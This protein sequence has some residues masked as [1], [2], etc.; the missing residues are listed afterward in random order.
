MEMRTRIFRFVAMSAWD[1]LAPNIISHPVSL[2]K[3]FYECFL[4]VDPLEK[5]GLLKEARDLSPD[6]IDAIVQALAA[7]LQPYLPGDRFNA[8]QLILMR[9]LVACLKAASEPAAAADPGEMLRKSLNRSILGDG[10]QQLA[11]VH[12]KPDQLAVGRS[13]VRAGLMGHI[14]SRG[15]QPLPPDPPPIP[16]YELQSVLGAGGFS[17]VYLAKEIASGQLRAVKVGPIEDKAR[18]DREIFILKSI[19]SPYISQYYQ[20]GELPG[21]FWIALEYLGTFTLSHL[22]RT[23]LEPDTALLLA[24]QILR[25]LVSLH[26]AG[27]IH[28][29]LTPNNIMID[30]EFRLKIIDFGLAKTLPFAL[31]QNAGTMTVGLTGTPMYMSPEQIHGKT[32]LAPSTDMWSFGVILYEML[33]GSPPFVSTNFMALGHEIQTAEIDFNHAQIPVEVRASLERCLKR[34]VADRWANAN[35][36]F[37]GFPQ[38]VMAARERIR[39]NRYRDSWQAVINKRLLQRFASE[40]SGQLP[41]GGPALFLALAHREGI[42]ELDEGRL[43]ALMAPVLS[44][45]SQIEAANKSV[46]DSRLQFS[47]NALRLPGDQLAR[48]LDS[49]RKLEET[50]QARQTELDS[51]VASLLVEDLKSWEEVQR[52]RQAMEAMA[53]QKRQEERRGVERK[54]QS[55]MAMMFFIIIL[56]LWISVGLLSYYYIDHIES[57]SSNLDREHILI[58]ILIANPIIDIIIAVIFS[59]INN[60]IVSNH[61]AAYDRRHT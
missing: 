15:P 13:M 17:T 24:E 34:D 56:L 37:S 38:I 27:I 6:D 46:Q 29:D 33:T 57:L 7:Q 45:Q 48:E 39:H 25:G 55:R 36:A 16:G 50:A 12:L 44:H 19:V 4:L 59:I 9:R 21:Q 3:N 52:H 1:I 30:N 20:H 11:H 5:F 61:M 49:L 18:F 10:R 22:I 23:C 47:Q 58:A 8:E 43:A 54:T 60:T 41:D 28:R 32:K 42:K 26:E 51:K 35:D 53:T 31:A 2:V 40:N 14:S